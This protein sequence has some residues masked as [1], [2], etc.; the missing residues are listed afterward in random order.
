[1]KLVLTTLFVYNKQLFP[2]FLSL[3]FVSAYYTREIDINFFP[4][5]C[6]AIFRMVGSKVNYVHGPS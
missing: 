1:M 3:K 2:I 5:T 6:V 4:L